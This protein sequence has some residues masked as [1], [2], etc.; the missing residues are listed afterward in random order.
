MI[1]STKDKKE[2]KSLYL[3]EWGVKLTDSEAKQTAKRLVKLFR[4]I[5]KIDD[6]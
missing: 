6:K 4:L 3:K 5:K 2:L 1:L